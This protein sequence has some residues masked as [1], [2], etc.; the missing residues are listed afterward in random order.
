MQ[1]VSIAADFL[2]WSSDYGFILRQPLSKVN[3][4]QAQQLMKAWIRCDIAPRPALQQFVGNIHDSNHNTT[5]STVD[6]NLNLQTGPFLSMAVKRNSFL[7]GVR[8]Q[9]GSTYA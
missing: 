5:Q 2:Y 1:L 7:H 4:R 6:E 8:R 9:S 3:G